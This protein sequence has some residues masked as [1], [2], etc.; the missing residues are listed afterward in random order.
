MAASDARTGAVPT[1]V[2]S[3]TVPRPVLAP[4]LGRVRPPSITDV[5]RFAGVS[6]QTVSRV[7]NDHPSVRPRTRALVDAA[8]R[9]LGY[10]PNTA[11]RALAGGASRVIGVL[12]YGRV[13]IGPAST[14]YAVEEQARDAGYSVSVVNLDSPEAPA[15]RAAAERLLAQRVDGVVAVLP[16]LAAGDALHQGLR[17]LPCVLVDGTLEH[18]EANLVRIDQEHGARTATEHLL[19]LGHATVWHV[20][21]PQD[22]YQAR[23]RKAAWRTALTDAGREVM[24]ALTG[25]WS[26]RSGYEAGQVLCRMADVTAVFVANDQMAVGV[27]RA[28]QESGRR[29]PQDISVVG[30][31][32]IPEA[33][34]LWPPLTTVRQDF[35][36]VG[37]QALRA[38]L[39]QIEWGSATAGDVVLVPEL[40]V[41]GST[42]ARR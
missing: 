40:V 34:Y 39:P 25:D 23:V 7:L 21:G 9:E 11:A 3:G 33:A 14:L 19:G 37:R 29:V 5:A 13:H 31:D 2:S 8:I 30:F 22:W 27:L 16:L 41:R 28:L 32:D 20:A 4:T 38:L 1:R 12:T 17:D 15:I 24:P 35:T 26:A 10:R 42:A 36:E 6:H 18:V